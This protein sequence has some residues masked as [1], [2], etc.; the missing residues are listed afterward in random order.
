MQ[1]PRL[2]LR[3]AQ[4]PDGKTLLT[5]VDALADYDKLPHPDDE[6]KK[7]LLHDAF[8]QKR[9]DV[10]LA[11]WEGKTVGYAVLLETYSTFV[12]RPTLFM[13]DLFVLPE[14]RGKHVGYE[15]FRYGLKEAVR[16]DCGRME[17]L[18]LDWNKPALGFYDHAG[19]NQLKGWVPFRLD[20]AKI[21]SLVR[22]PEP[23][24]RRL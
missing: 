2:V 17:W 23:L 5:L 7:R 6:A 20:R 10:V 16:R 12:A 22:D 4:Q 15:L 9:F 8:V 13:E 21:E 24:Q 3:P 14:F 1:D 18:V 19:A 11:E